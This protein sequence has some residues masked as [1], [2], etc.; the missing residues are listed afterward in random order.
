MTREDLVELSGDDGLLFADGFD[1][2][3]LGVMQRCGQPAV[4]VYDRDRCIEV[5]VEE[6]MTED[7]AEEHFQF[8]VEGGWLGE[9]T[10]AYLVKPE[11][12]D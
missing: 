9:R 10:P 1:A 6:G 5:L 11:L 12:T 3:L 8:N 2:A 4:V 7:E